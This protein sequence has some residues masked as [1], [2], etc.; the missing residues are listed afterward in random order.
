MDA[1][2]KTKSKDIL[3]GLNPPPGTSVKS[4]AQGP[5]VV[6]TMRVWTIFPTGEATE[7]SFMVATTLKGLAQ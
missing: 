1:Q 2:L 6:I 7:L 5:T 3:M 4:L